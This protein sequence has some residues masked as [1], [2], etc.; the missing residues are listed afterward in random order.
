[1]DDTK[2]V[3]M[4]QAL[5]QLV[6]VT[7]YIFLDIKIEGRELLLSVIVPGSVGLQQFK[8]TGMAKLDS[9]VQEVIVLLLAVVEDHVLMIVTLLQERHF[10][11]G[12]LVV[13]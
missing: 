2:L 9:D 4:V 12:K 8:K 11:G 1:M 5:R 3:Q 10:L 6:Q 7:R 13:L